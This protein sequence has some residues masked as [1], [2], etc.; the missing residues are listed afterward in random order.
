MNVHVERSL[1]DEGELRSLAEWAPP[2]G[3]LSVMV[4]ADPGDR[5]EGWRAQLKDDVRAAVAPHENGEHERKIA[6]RA[7]A[8]RLLD[9]LA[10]DVPPSARTVVGFVEVAREE[11]TE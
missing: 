9:R 1:P 7:T 6:L 5:S 2:L 4:S 3:V 8:E 10:E 11:A